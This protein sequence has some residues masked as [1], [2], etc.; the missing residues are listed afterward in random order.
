MF[1]CIDRVVPSTM[2]VHMQVSDVS[3]MDQGTIPEALNTYLNQLSELYVKQ[4]LF[5]LFLLNT[6]L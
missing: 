1:M 6:L 2:D 4:Y 3:S 5:C